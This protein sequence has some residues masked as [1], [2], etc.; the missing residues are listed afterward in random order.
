METVVA[1][2]AP[3]EYS[4]EDDELVICMVIAVVVWLIYTSFFNADPVRP[5]HPRQVN[6]HWKRNGHDVS[7]VM[8]G[9]GVVAKVQQEF[10]DKITFKPKWTADRGYRADGKPN[11]VPKR[12]IVV[13]VQ[14]IQDKPKFKAYKKKREAIAKECRNRSDAKS[15]Q[16]ELKR[17]HPGAPRKSRCSQLELAGSDALEWQVNERYVF[18][19]PSQDRA[20]LELILKSGLDSTK[21]NLEKGGLLHSKRTGGAVYFAE[22]PIKSDEYGGP[23]DGEAKDKLHT[24]FIV[25]ATFGSYYYTTEK[26]PKDAGPTKGHG[27][28]QVLRGPTQPK[29]KYHSILNH[30]KSTSGFNEFAIAENAQMYIEYV[31]QY[32][33]EY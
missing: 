16:E 12:L 17:I 11:R 33:R 1:F 24:M 6:A 28:D 18:H 2:E 15:L 22:Y 30:R 8:C 5:W 3:D 23:D 9:K 14:R 7:R 19:C 25:R 32:K 20:T 4:W 31:V 10:D 26:Q 27:L 29:G 13:S 21:A